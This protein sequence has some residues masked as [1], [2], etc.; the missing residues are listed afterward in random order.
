MWEILCFKKKKGGGGGGRE[1]KPKLTTYLEVVFQ[2]I[3]KCKADWKM[4]LE[5][6]LLELLLWKL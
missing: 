6:Y 1:K 3:P 4:E 5:K 2:L